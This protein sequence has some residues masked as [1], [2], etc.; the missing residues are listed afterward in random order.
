MWIQNKID[1]YLD[2]LDVLEHYN[3]YIFLI[4]YVLDFKRLAGYCFSIEI[5]NVMTNLLYF[6]KIGFYTNLFLIGF[7]SKVYD[8]RGL[9]RDYKPDDYVSMS[10][11]YDIERDIETGDKE[12]EEELMNII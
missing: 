10:F 1:L 12:K 9:F 11:G 8:L 4:E 2:I 5:I 7:D 3:V 6:D